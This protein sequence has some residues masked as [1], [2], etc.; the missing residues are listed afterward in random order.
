MNTI[1]SPQN[2][3]AIAKL[4][5]LIGW[6]PD[7]L[8]NH[9]LKETLDLFADSGGGSLEGFL[10]SIYFDDHVAGTRVLEQVTEAIRWQFDAELPSSFKG[11]IRKHPGSR[12]DVAAEYVDRDGELNR[13]CLETKTMFPPLLADSGTSTLIGVVVGGL[14]SLISTV[15]VT[16]W[17]EQLKR[18][19]ERR[20]FCALS[21]AA[22][23]DIYSHLTN[24]KVRE[25]LDKIVRD[26]EQYNQLISPEIALP[27]RGSFLDARIGRV[28][29]S[30]ATLPEPLMLRT[31][32][33]ITRLRGIVERE[34]H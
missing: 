1:L 34:L 31:S 18:N 30:L 4:A 25:A 28:E 23:R 27:I 3:H 6:T 16:T 24:N 22:F 19:T 5:Q 8:V 29:H 33:L 11:E 17:A 7:R 14:I 32:A 2:S 21:A 15:G 10:G 9:L 26:S 20:R 13:V 12:F